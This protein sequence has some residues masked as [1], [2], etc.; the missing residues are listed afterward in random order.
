MATNTFIVRTQATEA[1]I[2]AISP[3]I[4]G[5]I[6]RFRQSPKEIILGTDDNNKLTDKELDKIISLLKEKRAG[7]LARRTR[8]V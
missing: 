6:L 5:K 7:E 2:R 1:E 8:G 3:D 4:D